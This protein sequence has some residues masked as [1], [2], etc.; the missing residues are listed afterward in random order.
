[1]GGNVFECFDEQGDRWRKY[2]KTL[3]TLEAHVKKATM[4]ETT[5]VMRNKPA[6]L[7]P[8]RAAD[9]I[10]HGEVKQVREKRKH[11]H[12]Q[13]LSLYV[14]SFVNNVASQ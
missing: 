10:C 9:T 11:P 7:N 8:S 3:E 12:Q 13:T 6:G 14:R 1:M 4:S 2:A 5:I